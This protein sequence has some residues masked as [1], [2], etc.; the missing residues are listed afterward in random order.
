M[1]VGKLQ[2]AP[3]SCDSDVQCNDGMLGPPFFSKFSEMLV[4]EF[5]TS[6]PRFV[7]FV[8]QRVRDISVRLTR[9]RLD[10]LSPHPL[11]I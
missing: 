2:S 9:C 4:L 10:E 5:N 3:E 1:V 8:C 7:K 6:N 11:G